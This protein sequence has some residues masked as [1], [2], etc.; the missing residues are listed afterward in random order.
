MYG[1]LIAK[2]VLVMWLM[3]MRKGREAEDGRKDYRVGLQQYSTREGAR[4]NCRPFLSYNQTRHLLWKHRAV[5][6]SGEVPQRLRLPSMKV[7]TS[8]DQQLGNT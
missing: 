5:N 6:W 7:R 1:K 8:R 4:M 2:K 3:L